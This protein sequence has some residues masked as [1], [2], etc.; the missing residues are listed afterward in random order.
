MPYGLSGDG[1]VVAVVRMPERET[2]VM[3]E[4]GIEMGI[5]FTGD[6]RR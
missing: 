3:P 1:P 6:K 4:T 5:D 2:I